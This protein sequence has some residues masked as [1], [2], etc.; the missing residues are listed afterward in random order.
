MVSVIG[1]QLMVLAVGGRL[2]ILREVVNPMTA[3]II[4]AP[5]T[6]YAPVSGMVIRLVPSMVPN[7]M[8][9][10]VPIS[11]RPLPPVSSS[12]LN[13]CGNKLYFKGPNKV[14]C[15]PMPNTQTISKGIL[16]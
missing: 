6:Q 7:K 15:R 4:V 12:G 5:A 2:G 9:T 16:L 11:T 10:N 1:F 14:L 8:A 13:T 3:I